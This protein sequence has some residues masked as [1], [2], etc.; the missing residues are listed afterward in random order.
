MRDANSTESSPQERCA[1]YYAAQATI[2]C[3]RMGNS[4]AK[5]SSGSFQ[6]SGLLK[7][8]KPKFVSIFQQV[9][10][11]SAVPALMPKK[12]VTLAGTRERSRWQAEEWSPHLA[13][14]SAQ[15]SLFASLF[16]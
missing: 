7:R 5:F 9:P 2:T 13:V 11:A 10:S 1:S 8:L 15:S 12:E 3:P 6:T 14:P 4:K 16:K